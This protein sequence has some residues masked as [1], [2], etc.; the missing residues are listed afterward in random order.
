MIEQQTVQEN[1]K[2]QYGIYTKECALGLDSFKFTLE[3]RYIDFPDNLFTC[4]VISKVDERDKELFKYGEIGEEELLANSKLVRT[5]KTPFFYCLNGGLTM[6][7][8]TDKKGTKRIV[9]IINSR[10]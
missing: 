4:R 7:R 10:I 6:Q 5:N 2:L 3:E 1:T 9:F 8:S